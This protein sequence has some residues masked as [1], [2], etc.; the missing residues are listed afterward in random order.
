MSLS[1]LLGIG[2]IKAIFSDRHDEQDDII[3]RIILDG[4][5]TVSI[6]EIAIAA[7]VSKRHTLTEFTYT[8]CKKIISFAEK[9]STKKELEKL[10]ARLNKEVNIQQNRKSE[11]IKNKAKFA[12]NHIDKRM[13]EGISDQ[14]IVIK[15]KRPLSLHYQNHKKMMDDLHNK[16]WWGECIVKEKII[17]PHAEYYRMKI[18]NWVFDTLGIDNTYDLNNSCNRIYKKR[19]VGIMTHQYKNC[20]K[21][22]GH[23]PMI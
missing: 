23:D 22:C 5:N 2:A 4:I 16:T 10:K 18:P 1:L 20:L 14:T 15:I 7:G 9:H 12:K 8:D 17:G 13:K 3:D 21:S 11:I 19:I 6:K